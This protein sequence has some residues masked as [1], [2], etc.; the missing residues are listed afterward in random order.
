MRLFWIT[1]AW[2]FGAAFIY[3]VGLRWSTWSRSRGRLG[4]REEDETPVDA[5]GGLHDIDRGFFGLRLWLVQSGFRSRG[6]PRMFVISAITCAVAGV[7]TAYLI[8]A[9]GGLSQ[10]MD[11]V[12]SLGGATGDMLTAILVTTPW[13]T[14]ILIASAPW[15][16]VRARRRA[17][18]TAI[19]QDLPITLELMATLSQAGLGLD[20]TVSKLIDSPSADRPFI[21]EMRL[22]QFEVLTGVP[23]IHCL[24][25]L[26]QRVGVGS[27]SIFISAI[28]QAEQVG[29]GMADVLQRQA[30]DLRSRRREN[31][32]AIAQAVPVKLTF[33][34]VICFLPGIFV[35]T[36]G[37]TLHQ[38]IQL[39]E[40][41]M[42][43]VN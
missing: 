15:V 26:S 29:A 13:L 2:I 33:P 9:T 32:M 21:E 39:A 19:E 8:V 20:A 4:S 1:G 41:V 16:F 42:R 24:R 11:V 23:R 12:E 14:L 37:P 7:V 36:I 43:G 25:R 30:D 5:A 34:L 40:T 38:F 28:V 27:V 3:F 18:V 35:T 6:A 22:Y 17:R 10:G 31:A